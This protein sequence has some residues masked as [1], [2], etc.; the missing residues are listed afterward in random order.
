MTDLQTIV[1]V[2]LAALD[3][4]LLGLAAA[5]ARVYLRAR[6]MQP[7]DLTAPQHVDTVRKSWESGLGTSP[8]A[9]FEAPRPGGDRR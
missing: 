7:E 5:L 1:V 4:I 6:P 8:Y 9:G 2:N 3:V